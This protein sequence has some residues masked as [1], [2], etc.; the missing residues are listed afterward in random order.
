[1]RNF[2]FHCLNHCKNLLAH[3]ISIPR[4]INP[5]FS[6]SFEFIGQLMLVVISN[7]LY[8]AT[9]KFQCCM[10]AREK[11]YL[12]SPFSLTYLNVTIIYQCIYFTSNWHMLVISF[13]P[14][15]L[16]LI[17]LLIYTDVQTINKF[18]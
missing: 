1:M 2:Y 8:P 9:S 14:Y 6:T 10:S 16:Y 5:G 17:N 7:K 12:L 15:V 18:Q 13:C 4:N 3:F 11:R